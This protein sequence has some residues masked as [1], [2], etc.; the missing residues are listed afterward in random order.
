M[1]A[2]VIGRVRNTPLPKNQ[3][4]LPLFEAIS[5]SIDAIEESGRD[6]SDGAIDVEIIRYAMLPS[7]SDVGNEEDNVF[8]PPILSFEIR[9]NGVGFTEENWEAFNV[10]DT[11]IKVAKGGRG[12][13]R[14]IWLKAFE[15]VEVDSI[16]RLDAG[17]AHRTFKFSLAN[18]DGI[19]DYDYSEESD[20]AEIRTT[21]R[22]MGFGEDYEKRIPRSAKKIGHRIVEHFLEYYVLTNMPIVRIFDGSLDGGRLSLDDVYEDLIADTDRQQFNVKDEAFDITH[23][24]LNVG[25]SVKH[26]VCYCASRRVVVRKNISNTMIPNLPTTLTTDGSDEAFVYAG[27]VSS[28]FL[29]KHVSQHRLGFDITQEKT[30]MFPAEL[31]FSE[32]EAATTE[33]IRENLRAFTD[34]VKARKHERIQE[35]VNSKAPEY[36]HILK[37]HPDRLDAVLPDVS[38]RNLDGALYDIHRDIESEIRS[39]AR[40]LLEKGVLADVD[41]ESYDE[42][43]EKFSRFWEEMNE[44]GKANLAK[45]IVHRKLILSFLEDALNLQDAGKYSREEAIHQFIFPLKKTSDEI[46]YDQHNL[47][48]VDEKLAYHWYLASDMSLSSVPDLDSDSRLRPDLIAFFDRPIAVVEEDAPFNSGIV[49]F[50]FKRPMRDNYDDEDNPIQQILGYVNA[51]KEGTTIDRNGRPVRVPQAT[52]F[53]CYVISDL[54]PRLTAQAEYAN[55]SITPDGEGYFGYNSNIGAYIEVISFDKLVRDSKRRNRRLFEEL[56]L[57]ETFNDNDG[58]NDESR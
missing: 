9:D 25:A 46:P 28:Q 19:S 3:G 10:A 29:D 30:E 40:Q 20:G 24:K 53:Y 39:E 35:F 5:N 6:P 32:V 27:Y 33:V 43:L 48:I 2:D 17:L 12:V 38:D 7:S 34:I 58:E 41:E 4:L 37:N 44:V 22:L 57:P 36:R 55:L 50:E 52:P 54:T 11:Q 23:F 49:I 18:S 16:F 26:H 21:V 8:Y 51:I 56:N 13:G 15:K 31:T 14:F 45:Y 1:R 42:Q 47:W